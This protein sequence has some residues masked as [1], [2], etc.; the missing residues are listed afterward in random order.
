MGDDGGKEPDPVKMAPLLAGQRL[1]GVIRSYSQA[2]GFGF[3]VCKETQELLGR[4]V[5]IQRQEADPVSATVGATVSFTIEMNKEGKP[6]ARNVM[7]EVE[8]VQR[9]AP[10][11]KPSDIVATQ[12]AEEM[13]S[14]ALEKSYVGMIKSYNQSNGFGFIKCDETFNIFGRDVY[15]Q[16]SNV[17]GFGVGDWVD[18]KLN[19]DLEKGT[20][21]A[22][23]L[24]SP[25]EDKDDGKE[26]CGTSGIGMVGMM[27][28]MSML[29]LPLSLLAGC[30]P[31]ERSQHFEAA[32]I[33]SH[34]PT[35][36]GMSKAEW[37]QQMRTDRD[38]GKERGGKLAKLQE[39]VDKKQRFVGIV[40]CF[41]RARGFGFIG[42]DEAQQVSGSDVFL[43]NE[44]RE[45]F[46]VGDVVSF[47][48]EIRNNQA[49]A[50]DLRA[51]VGMY[52]RGEQSPPRYQDKERRNSRDRAPPARSTRGVRRNRSRSR[53]PSTGRRKLNHR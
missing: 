3:I 10:E 1:L 16:W 14:A 12:I 23:E 53:S 6:K 46:D 37:S 40:R 52:D 28:M 30:G 32:D 22:R 4:D 31:E 5:F 34:M 26:G 11:G 36:A 15:L 38:K 19:I 43:H 44:Q 49:R 7:L 47:A 42:C 33:E 27:G 9:G 35:A 18:F 21:Q 51:S 13:S 20:P 2:T 48:I 25:A 41:N 17:N 45:D 50:K 8:G 24:R 29:G 39:L